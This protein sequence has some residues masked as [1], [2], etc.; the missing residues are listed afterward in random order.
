MG[1]V[2]ISASYG[3][4]GD[5]I[6]RA[7]AERLELQFLDRAIPNAVARQLHLSEEDVQSL[8]ERVP[9]RWERIFGSIGELDPPVTALPTATSLR[10]A[11]DEL[12][13]QGVSSPEYDPSLPQGS[14]PVRA[15]GSPESFRLATE[16]ILRG[17]AD[18]EGAVILGRCAMVV[19]AAHHDVLR[20]RLD[21]PL[22][23]RIA[24]V[25]AG[26]TDEAAARRSQKDVD[27]AR[28]QYARYFYRVSLA[29]SALYHLII[30]S[31]ALSVECCVDLI[32]RA[33]EGLFGVV[34]TNRD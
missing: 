33:S 7:V 21:G 31:S 18:A 20:V 27:G 24:R 14:L 29:D 2:T 23:A 12:R 8:D 26:G 5:R 16:T 32:C 6:G 25:V 1:S 9:G 19:L 13:G 34:P 28:E 17:V 3:S 4:Q 30:D 15:A 22:E 11:S 10:L